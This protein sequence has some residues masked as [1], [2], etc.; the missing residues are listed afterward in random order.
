L[1]KE[2]DTLFS[3][4]LIG[5]LLNTYANNMLLSLT[6]DDDQKEMLQKLFSAFNRHGVSTLTVIKVFAELFKAGD[7]ENGI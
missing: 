2:F 3:G 4:D 6:E 7:L 5:T 1:D